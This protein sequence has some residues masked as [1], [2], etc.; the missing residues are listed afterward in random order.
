MYIGIEIRKQIQTM[1]EKGSVIDQKL[2]WNRSGT[3]MVYDPTIPMGAV[4]STPFARE[5][6]GVKGPGSKILAKISF[7]KK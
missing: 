5:G 2:S 7:L 6:L 3:I 4:K 1:G